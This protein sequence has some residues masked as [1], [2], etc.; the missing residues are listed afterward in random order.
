MST[1]TYSARRLF[2]VTLG[3]C[4]LSQPFSHADDPRGTATERD[5]AVLRTS[6]TECLIGNNKSYD[7]DGREHRPGYNGIFR[8]TSIDQPVSPF[9]PAYAGWNLEHYFDGSARGDDR[10]FF[11]PRYAPMTLRRLSPTSVELHQ[12]TTPHYG[13]ESWTRLTVEEPYYV[14]ISH[15]C[16][17]TRDNYHGDFVGVF[18]ASYMNGPLNKSVYFLD[19]NATLAQ[20]VW[21]QFCTQRHDRDSTVRHRDDRLE[22]QFLSPGEALYSNFSPL[23]YST[24]FFYGRFRN[25]VVIYAFETDQTLRFAHSPTGGGPTPN[26]HDTNPA[27]DFQLIIPQPVAGTE[28]TLNGRLIYKKWEGREDVLAEVKQFYDLTRASR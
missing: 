28:Y 19:E 5:V 8:L 24:P 27:W 1:A 2:A 18:W 3:L 14:N 20:P 13:V 17:P 9:V 10:T 16:I 4:L 26:G 25:M 12:P 23:R 21:R 22:L 7:E 15:R 11:E 6:A